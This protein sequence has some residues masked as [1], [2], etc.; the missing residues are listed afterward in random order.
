MEEF[1]ANQWLSA[2]QSG[3]K[4]TDGYADMM[5][6]SGTHGLR[7]GARSMFEVLSNLININD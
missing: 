7:E 1:Y 2:K 4:I 3:L 5:A 6:K